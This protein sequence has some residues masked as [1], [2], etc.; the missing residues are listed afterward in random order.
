MTALMREI[1]RQAGL[2]SVE[3]RELLAERLLAT[4]SGAPL[5][6]LD[7]IWLEEAKRRYFLWKAGRSKGVSAG[8]RCAGR[9]P[10]RATSVKMVLD[11]CQRQMNPAPGA[12]RKLNGSA[13]QFR[14]R[15]LSAAGFSKWIMNPGKLCRGVSLTTTSGGSL[16]GVPISPSK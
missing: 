4:A 12:G 7:I 2:L 14:F 6:D 15:K 10:Q 1:E 5:T 16:L 8:R 9:Y 3:E 13:V 11:P